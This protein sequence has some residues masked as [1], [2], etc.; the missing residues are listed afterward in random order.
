M[1]WE[2]VRNVKLKTY[3]YIFKKESENGFFSQRKSCVIQKQIQNYYQNRD[4]IKNYHLK[5]QNKIEKHHGNRPEQKN[6]YEKQRRETDFSYILL[7]NL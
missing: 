5:N 7:C 4:K 1:K 2:N 3:L 6:N